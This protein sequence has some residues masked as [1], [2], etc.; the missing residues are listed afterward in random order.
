MCIGAIVSPPKK[1]HD[2]A[3]L[4]AAMLAAMPPKVKT[5]SV[6]YQYAI[7]DAGSKYSPFV[8]RFTPGIGF[9]YTPN[10]DQA[11]LFASAVDAANAI[12]ERDRVNHQENSSFIIVAV[13][14]TTTTTTP[15]KVIKREIVGAQQPTAGAEIHYALR[16]TKGYSAGNFITSV[17][18]RTHFSFDSADLDAAVLFDSA[19]EAE[20]KTKA[21]RESTS[22]N[23]W[24]VVPVAVTT[25]TP[26]PVTKTTREL[27]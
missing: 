9:G 21:G 17:D 12:T 5:P 27:A 10:L 6:S 25:T 2:Y 8:R 16:A 18:L 20:S 23:G 7:K 22:G 4:A 14:V 24:I 1:K 13:K 26:A 19:S 15:D 11:Q 3:A